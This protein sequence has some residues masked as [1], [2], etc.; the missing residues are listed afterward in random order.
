MDGITIL[1][2]TMILAGLIATAITL[3]TK[4]VT[5]TPRYPSP[6]PPPKRLNNIKKNTTMTQ[7]KPFYMIYVE[8]ERTPTYI[9][10]NLESAETEAK[11]L[12]GTLEKRAY[13]LMSIKSYELNKFKETVFQR[14]N[15]DHLPF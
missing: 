4:K 1:G 7:Q 12:A 8:G 11:R 3:T 9:H 10:S 15:E 13:I 6:P 14:D 5:G 2:G